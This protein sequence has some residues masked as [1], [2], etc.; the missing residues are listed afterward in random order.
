MIEKRGRKKGPDKERLGPLVL[1]STAQKL[2]RMAFE[3][4]KTLGE[5]LDH[6]FSKSENTNTK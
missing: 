2:K 3:A 1:I 6:M 4:G 5:L